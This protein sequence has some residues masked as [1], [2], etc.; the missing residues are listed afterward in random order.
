MSTLSDD[1]LDN[2]RQALIGNFKGTWQMLHQAIDKIP[3][4]RWH[5]GICER[6]PV[7]TE[8]KRW[9]FSFVVYHVIETAEFYVNTTPDTMEWGKKAGF[10]WEN[11]K[12]IKSDILPRITKELVLEYLA[13]IE[14]R[15]NSFVSDSTPQSFLEKDGFHWF[16]CI[17][18][19]LIYLLR[20][21]TYHV[22]EL[23]RMI[24]EWECEL[25]HWE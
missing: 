13:E 4:D 3:D 9:F 24:R 22:G 19:K 17:L 11:V 16:P 15:V 10:N 5:D 6:E 7:D 25:L 20:H 14:E 12:N 18:H 21:T 8:S 23:S 2:L 1:H